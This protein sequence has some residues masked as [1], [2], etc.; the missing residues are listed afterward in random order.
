M[1]RNSEFRS[2]EFW[3][4]LI[5]IAIT[6]T[7]ALTV[8]FATGEPGTTSVNSES[9]YLPAVFAALLLF[10]HVVLCVLAPRADQ[11]I[12]P[13]VAFLN[14]IGLVVIHRLDI[15]LGRELAERQI[16][17]TGLGIAVCAITLVILQD[18]KV[19]TRFSYLLGAVGLILLASPL[20]S[21]QP[22]ESDAT[23]WLMIG[24]FSIQ[25]GEIAKVLL[26]IFFAMLISNKRALF[27]VAE[28][29][30][31][32]IG[33]PR[34]RDLAPIAFIGAFAMIIM[35][36]TND[37]GPALL[38]FLTVFGMVYVATS[39]LSWLLIGTAAL[40]VGG[41]LLARSSSKIQQRI[42]NARDPLADFYNNGNQL[43]EALFGLSTG[44][45]TGSGLGQGYPQSIP[46]A[47]SDFI[48][49]AVGEELG[50]VGLT[51]VL[52]VFALLQCRFFFTALHARESFGKLLVTGFGIILTVQVFVVT[53]GISGLIPM[54]G[55][56]TPFMSAGGSSL[57]AN[58][59]IVAIVLRISH[60]TRSAEANGTEL[61]GKRAPRKSLLQPFP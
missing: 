31:F 53:G 2:R 54:T 13:T 60:S 34:L 41:S 44:G 25:P 12:L 36:L 57:L 56:T 29:R 27:A 35:A 51:A 4:L 26:V 18:H 8:D 20:V 47:F 15:A 11:I 32:G 22:V 28:H 43:S 14:G 45:L 9:L 1:L 52:L 49:A 5:A 24:P 10:M 23:I 16:L 40:L 50:L 21:P 33:F 19:L 48:L 42:E 38:L 58:Y 30:F 55:L 61:K 17:W 59:L 7:C 46:L 37:F 3:L 39:R 6:F